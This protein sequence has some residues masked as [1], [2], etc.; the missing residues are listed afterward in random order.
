[1]SAAFEKL[2]RLSVRPSTLF[3]ATV[4]CNFE[5]LEIFSV[6]AIFFFSLSFLFAY[7]VQHIYK[8]I[9]P[10]FLC[11]NWPSYHC[12]T[13]RR[14]VADLG[15]TLKWKR[16]WKWKNGVLNLVYIGGVGRYRRSCQCLR[17]IVTLPFLS[18]LTKFYW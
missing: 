5:M 15:K 18:H 8:L 2:N 1:M 17:S 16:K 10:L 6:T 14:I 4:T 12:G 3:V 11:H 13:R 7:L 9:S